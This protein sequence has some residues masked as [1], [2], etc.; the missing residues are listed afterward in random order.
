[1]ARASASGENGALA[2]RVA[3]LGDER[4]CRRR[5]HDADGTIVRFMMPPSNG[6]YLL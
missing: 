1:M 4:R 2:S 6:Q 3:A 5:H